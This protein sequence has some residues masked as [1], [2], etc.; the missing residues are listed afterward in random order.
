MGG[1]YY[2]VVA[3]LSI[4]IRIVFLFV[5]GVLTVFL[6]GAATLY[7][8]EKREYF[9]LMLG[10]AKCIYQAAQM[11]AEEAKTNE[12]IIAGWPGDLKNRGQISCLGDYVNLL[13]R[14]DYFKPGDLKAFAG[15]GYEQYPGTARSGLNGGLVPAF[16]ESNSAFKIYLIKESDPPNTVFLASKNFRYGQ[17]L[18]PRGILFGAR[19]FV[20][21]FKNG[22]AAI[23]RDMKLLNGL[24]PGGGTVES[25]ENCLN[26]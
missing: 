10:D 13:V 11:M 2:R 9:E 20:V 14:N 19:Q 3:Y 1:T 24:L 4:Q 5:C 17:S 23:Y 18:D 8:I 16:K 21:V 26:P 22:E 6:L 25:A 7:Y 12:N 15:I